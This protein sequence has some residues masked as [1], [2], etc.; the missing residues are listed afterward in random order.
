MGGVSLAG[1]PHGCAF[2]RSAV[3]RGESMGP[4]PACAR[5]ATMA[6]CTGASLGPVL[7]YSPADD[8]RRF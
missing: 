3:R 2:M 4:I 5:D 8:R 6:V 1:E 7:G